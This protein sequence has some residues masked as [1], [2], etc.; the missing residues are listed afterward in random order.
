MRQ[1]TGRGI[2]GA[3][4]GLVYNLGIAHD[5]IS[6]DGALVRNAAD[7]GDLP[8]GSTTYTKVTDRGRAA[9]GYNYDLTD[10]AGK[11]ALAR[12]ICFERDPRRDGP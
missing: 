2:N 11:L 9:G 3:T 4:A 5:E 6:A 7:D 1:Y 12:D 10:D 8:V